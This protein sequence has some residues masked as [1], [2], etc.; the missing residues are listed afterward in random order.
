MLPMSCPHCGGSL[1]MADDALGTTAC[2]NCG[3]AWQLRK[4][5][6]AKGPQCEDEETEY[7]EDEPA[8]PEERLRRL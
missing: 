6:V 3:C 1:I 7:E 8:T 4:V 2:Q 5:L